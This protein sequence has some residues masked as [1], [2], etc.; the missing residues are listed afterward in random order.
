[1]EK[2]ILKTLIYADI[3]DYPLTV[4]EI[5]KWLIGKKATLRQVEKTLYKLSRESRVKSQGEYYYLPRRSKL[6]SKRLRCGQQSLI[7]FRKAKMLSQILKL[8]PWVKLVGISGGLALNSASK[9]DDIDLFII[10][11]KNRLWVSR[12]FIIGLF[13]L[14]GQ[15]RKKGDQGRKI[16]GKFCINILLEEDK[17]EQQNKDIFI[18]HELLQMKPLWF[19]GG[20]YSK[21]LLDNEWVFKSLPNWIGNASQELRIMNYESRRKHKNRNSLISLLESFAKWFQLKIM[22]QSRGMERIEDGAL[23]FHPKDC[24]RGVLS[25]Y[26]QRVSFIISP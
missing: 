13:S 1:M 15:R 7:Y 12:L 24:R 9:K 14:I 26:K 17:L 3:F 20:I 25:K 6:V 18:A 4:F 11:S 10:I 8:I 2:A 19:R 23:Y 22:Q 16:A 21:Y 5:H